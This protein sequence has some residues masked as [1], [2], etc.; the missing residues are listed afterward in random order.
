ML[1]N[2][3]TYSFA[4]S[5]LLLAVAGRARADRFA[6][7]TFT[8]TTQPASTI[9]SG[10][11]G[12]TIGWGY[13]ITNNAADYLNVIDVYSDPFLATYGTP[14]ASIFD[15]PLVGP[16]LTMTESYDP[17]NTS[18]MF[19][20]FQ[21]TWDPTWSAGTTVTGDFF[22]EAQFCDSA[23]LTNCGSV[24][25]DSWGYTATVSSASGTPI[26]EPSPMLLLLSGLSGIGLGLRRRQRFSGWR[27]V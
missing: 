25:T 13:S 26:P 20:L 27:A 17:T 8:F 15:V 12:S 16:T 24:V 1:R 19:G 7:D 3:L 6:A 5:F 4:L 21:F 10:P 22:V 18:N 23:A 14:D 2:L 11:P 9:T